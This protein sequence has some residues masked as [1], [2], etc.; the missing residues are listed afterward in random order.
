MVQV[1]PAC[2]FENE[3]NVLCCTLCSTELPTSGVKCPNCTCA[4]AEG[5]EVCS[6]CGESLV[7]PQPTA[8]W[9][10]PICLQTAGSNLVDLDCLHRG[11]QPCLVLWIEACDAQPREPTCI[12]C[13]Q[14]EKQRPLADDE[15]RAIL[16][17]AAHAKRA[18]RLAESCVRLFYCP[19]CQHPYEL[20]ADV[21]KRPTVCRGCKET[22]TLSEEALD[23]LQAGS[24][25]RAAAQGAGAQGGSEVAGSAAQGSASC[26][27][28]GGGSGSGSGGGGGSG[29]T[30]SPICLTDSD[31][32][33]D[34]MTLRERSR[35]RKRESAS[36][37]PATVPASSDYEPASSE[38][39][40]SD[41]LRDASP[42]Q[43]QKC[44]QCGRQVSKYSE[45][46]C[47]KMICV[48]RCHFC[49]HCGKEYKLS[50]GAWRA[51]CRCNIERYGP[52]HSFPPTP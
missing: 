41:A 9:V 23:E 40:S 15:V 24:A 26:S 18:A 8:T 7:Q 28:G 11:C 22:V 5:A 34:T 10:C 6:A 17:D 46:D 30:E 37:A 35:K 14:Q 1:C 47:D 3:A 44:P 21:A 16:G 48:C 2:T 43:W 20:D 42:A 27:S 13:A 36:S 45:G 52:G 38:P 12:A 51:P 31:E 39:A 50:G 32:E 19:R 49:F 33:E 25:G 4:N 29:E